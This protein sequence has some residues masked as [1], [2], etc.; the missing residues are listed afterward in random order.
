[1]EQIREHFAS[2]CSDLACG[3]RSP[4]AHLMTECVHALK[5]KVE[6]RRRGFNREMSALDVL[7]LKVKSGSVVL[8]VSS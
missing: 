2:I 1:L 8:V 5:K 4:I 3:A 6:H 7:V